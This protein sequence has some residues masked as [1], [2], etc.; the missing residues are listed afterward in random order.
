MVYAVVMASVASDVC[1]V[2]WYLMCDFSITFDDL[3]MSGA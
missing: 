2:H 3:I 1:T